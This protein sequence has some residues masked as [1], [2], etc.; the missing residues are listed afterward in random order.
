MRELNQH[1]QNAKLQTEKDQLQRRID[2]T[3]NEI[4]KIVYQLYNLTEAEIQQIEHT[5]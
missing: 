4:D 5:K 1:Y 3:D 2:Y